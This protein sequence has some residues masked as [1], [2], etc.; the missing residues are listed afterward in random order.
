MSLPSLIKT[1]QFN[2]NQ[3]L[4]TTGVALT[5][6]RTG[7]LAVKNS[8]KG[9]GVWTDSTG[10]PTTV[11][12]PWT[13]RYSC[14]SSVA[15][16]AGDGVDRWSVITD[17]VWATEGSA[18]SWIV[19][20]N[21]NIA[22]NFE[23]LISCSSGS[24]SNAII[25]IS[26]SAGFSGGTTTARPTATDEIVTINGAGWGITGDNAGKLHVMISSDGQCTRLIMHSSNSPIMCWI[27]DKPQVAVSGWSNPSATLTLA[28]A[29]VILNLL[30][31]ANFNGRGVS[32]MTMFLTTEVAQS[33][34]L[35]ATM[36]TANDLSGNYPFFPTGLY[37]NTASNKGRH[38]SLFDL[39]YGITAT[40]EGD[41]YP[42][43]GTTKQFSQIGD[44]IFPWNQTTIL[45][46]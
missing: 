31:G 34:S 25:A 22:S 28:T 26:P 37:S 4:P 30:N 2:V 39:W 35:P 43:T 1:W 16:T 6:Q 42:A 14:N 5:T 18:H 13:I 24:A 36:I 41:Q 3:S 12:S 23:L 15:G 40:N 29:P 7:L 46:A 33:T 44:L 20:R 10:T 11:S 19:L 17:L 32:S 8:L 27:I 9:S 21:T 38:G 45:I